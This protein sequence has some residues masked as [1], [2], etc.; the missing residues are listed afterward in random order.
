M[1]GDVT[2]G[3]TLVQSL[4]YKEF[5]ALRAVS[6][7]V[8]AT[9]DGHLAQRDQ[10]LAR[11]VQ[12]L[13]APA[14]SAFLFFLYQDIGRYASPFQILHLARQFPFPLHSELWRAFGLA[15][16]LPDAGPGEILARLAALNG[17]L[18]DAG[19]RQEIGDLTQDKE[20]RKALLREFDLAATELNPLLH[21]E[22]GTLSFEMPDES[23]RGLSGT[24]A[25]QIRDAVHKR[26]KA[27]METIK[28]EIVH[29]G[30]SRTG[31]SDK[32]RR[33]IAVDENLATQRALDRL[34]WVLAH[35]E[36]A[37]E[38]V[39]VAHTEGELHVWANNPDDEME[40]HLKM[41]IEAGREQDEAEMEDLTTT[42]DDLWDLL[43][44]SS[45]DVRSKEGGDLH[46]AERRL[47]KAIRFLADLQQKWA[48]LKVSAHEETYNLGG[49]ERKVHTEMQAATQLLQ[50]RDRARA[51]A[52]RDALHLMDTIVIAIGISKLC[53]LKC[54]L[55][56]LA[57]RE[58]GIR[59]DVTGTHLTTYAWPVSPALVAPAL[60]KAILGVP[61]KP[62]SKEDIALAAAIDD[63]LQRKAVI[64]AIDSFDH[65]GGM[66]K[67]GY[68]SSED[69]EGLEFTYAP[70]QES[71]SGSEPESDEGTLK[72][73]RDDSGEGRQSENDEPEQKKPRNTAWQEWQDDME[74]EESVSE[75]DSEDDY[76]SP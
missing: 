1:L 10:D 15:L 3:R 26:L 20:R 52:K 22:T 28:D 21:L 67:T 61:A 9:M 4:T 55:G 31:W 60:L 6:K 48:E 49:V 57:M 19:L 65:S 70:R 33:R 45:L 39:A 72:R 7:R 41:L 27:K 13:S 42:F 32:Y 36:D 73:T 56:I 12:A 46:M 44:K 16:N 63:E 40:K 68:V 18:G 37:R 66:D 54:Y 51:K 23:L 69:E 24:K 35:L 29:A 5:M 30:G 11:R 75:E 74:G 59:F 8:M 71:D 25:E 38:C 58:Q 2:M 53:C 17:W 34:A 64:K 47:L 14:R 62:T 50:N 76:E 43:E